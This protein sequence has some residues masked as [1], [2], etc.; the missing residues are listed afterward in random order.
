M[1]AAGKA[2]QDE[3]DGCRSV[4]DQVQGGG[5]SND[6]EWTDGGKKVTT[7][8]MVAPLR[9]NYAQAHED[10]KTTNELCRSI[11]GEEKEEKRRQ[12]QKN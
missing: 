1:T 7:M 5:W 2:S 6:A 9:E 10:E 3:E 12:D 4:S 8:M 11:S